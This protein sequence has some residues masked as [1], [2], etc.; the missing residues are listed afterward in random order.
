MFKQ[1]NKI[2]PFSQVLVSILLLHMFPRTWIFLR[3]KQNLLIWLKTL[4]VSLRNTMTAVPRPQ[5]EGMH[6]GTTLPFR[7]TSCLAA[8]L[9]FILLV[10]Y[11]SRDKRNFL[12]FHKDLITEVEVLTK[13]KSFIKSSIF[14]LTYFSKFYKTSPLCLHLPISIYK[15][16]LVYSNAVPLNMKHFCLCWQ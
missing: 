11:F 3:S 7:H 4:P 15:L 14:L 16:S 13:R 1:P 10:F 2:V 8:L 5:E 12:C 9:I 6:G